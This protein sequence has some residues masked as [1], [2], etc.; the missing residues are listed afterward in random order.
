M[1][2]VPAVGRGDGRA[3]EADRDGMMDGRIKLE[4]I[5]FSYTWTWEDHMAW[6]TRNMA[7]DQAK[8]M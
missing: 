5:G 2:R 7:P 3:D 4:H 8:A 1:Q 6:A